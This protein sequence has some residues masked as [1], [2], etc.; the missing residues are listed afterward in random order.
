MFICQILLDALAFFLLSAVGVS[1]PVRPEHPVQN[2][3]SSLL[4]IRKIHH[5]SQLMHK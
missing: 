5:N 4:S 1:T 2:F 3:C